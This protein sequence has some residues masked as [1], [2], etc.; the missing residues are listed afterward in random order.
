MAVS[1]VVLLA[2]LLFLFSS[3]LA[4]AALE[5]SIDPAV[6]LGDEAVDSAA[7]PDGSRLFVLTRTGKILVLD[8]TGKVE[9]TINGSFKAESVTVSPD[10]KRLYL[11]GKG[12]KKVQIISLFDRFSIPVGESPVKG[13]S[14]AAVTVAVFSD[15]QCPYCARIIPLLDQLLE[16][17][18]GKVKVVFKN[19]PLPNHNMARPAA[20]AALA[21]HLQ[22]KFWDYHDKVFAANTQ[23]SDEKLIAIAR[24]LQL[25]MKKF[26]QDRSAPQVLNQIEQDLILGQSVGIRGTPTIFINGVQLQNGSRNAFQMID[27]EL[28]RL[29]K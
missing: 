8:A 20:Q 7:A 16:T 29:S 11:T 22:G 5:W 2:A 13:D 26:E 3:S 18:P 14:A 24:E 17:Y 15:F 27:A 9:S 25:D 19:I 4:C 1:R 6:Q 12:E 23:L 21:A 10:G 28:Q